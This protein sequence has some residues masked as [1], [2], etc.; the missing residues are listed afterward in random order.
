[1]MNN[2]NM[3]AKGT[4]ELAASSAPPLAY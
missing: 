2:I 1:M 4:C 3:A